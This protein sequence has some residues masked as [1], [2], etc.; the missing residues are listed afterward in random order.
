MGRGAGVF[1]EVRSLAPSLRMVIR[2]GGSRRLTDAQ[3]ELAENRD[4]VVECEDKVAE[5]RDRLT[6]LPGK[7]EKNKR[8]AETDLA[9]KLGRK[10]EIERQGRVIDEARELVDEALESE[11]TLRTDHEFLDVGDLRDKVDADS[12]SAKHGNQSSPRSSLW[13]SACFRCV[14]RLPASSR[15]LASL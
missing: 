1:L 4:D 7:R 5:L 9:E 10:P 14:K 15:R 11:E 3:A 6:A 8:Y 13:P 12:P 2:R